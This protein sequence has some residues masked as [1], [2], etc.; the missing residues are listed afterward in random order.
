[1][2]LVVGVAPASRNVQ[3]LKGP[4]QRDV[5]RL[6]VER[7]RLDRGGAGATDGD[8]DRDDDEGE[9]RAPAD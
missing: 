5:D 3:P 8:E 9:R 6:G 2:A 7:V 4:G 1:M